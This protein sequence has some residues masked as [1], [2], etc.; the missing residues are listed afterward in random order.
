MLGAL[1]GVHPIAEGKVLVRPGARVGYMEQKAVSDAGGATVREIAMSRMAGYAT[2]AAALEECTV[3]VEGG[4]CS[5]ETIEAFSAAQEA[6]EACDG[7]AA[8]E[9]VAR[10][11]SGLG[12]DA[13]RDLERRCD[14]FSG[15]WQA[16]RR[17]DG[18]RPRARVFRT[19]PLC[20]R[21][22]PMRIGGIAADKSG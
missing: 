18:C 3:L 12:F 2:A 11:L 4:D 6:F 16:R 8:E 15:G 10:V 19:L 21:G 20:P 13:Q 7:Y 17:I 5:D 22:G 9:R 14:E 1:M